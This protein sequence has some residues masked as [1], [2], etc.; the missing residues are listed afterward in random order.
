MGQT[1]PKQAR[2][3]RK[4]H[5]APC[6]PACT[7]TAVS[8]TQARARSSSVVTPPPFRG[9]RTPLRRNPFSQR[10]SSVYG[11]AER[12]DG[13]SRGA[14]DTHTHTHRVAAAYRWAG[15]GGRGMLRWRGHH[16]GVAGVVGIGRLGSAVQPRAPGTRLRGCCVRRVGGL[17]R[18]DGQLL[19]A[20]RSCVRADLPTQLM[21][22]CPNDADSITT[23]RMI[24]GCWASNDDGP[25]AREDNA[26]A[27][28]REAY[29]FDRLAAHKPNGVMRGVTPGRSP[30]ALHHARTHTHRRRWRTAG[31][32]M[33]ASARSNSATGASA[34]LAPAASAR[35]CRTCVNNRTLSVTAPDVTV[36]LYRTAVAN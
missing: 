12:G 2:H 15:A 13:A 35:W 26:S 14:L 21:A 28:G 18:S 5:P 10:A 33:R 19:S 9:G 30:N 22:S 20:D 8:H 4:L 3:E 29:G 23:H 16:Q 34:L 32:L 11:W 6:P 7:G 1:P 31:R 36:C 17:P 25:T 24:V 27:P